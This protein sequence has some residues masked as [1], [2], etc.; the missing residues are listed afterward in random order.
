[1]EIV[2][3]QRKLGK[4]LKDIMDLCDLSCSEMSGMVGCSNYTLYRYANGKATMPKHMYIVI[5]LALEYYMAEHDILDG[6]EL[7]NELVDDKKVYAD[8]DWVEEA[9]KE[10]EKE[11]K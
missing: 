3:K 8:S 9:F 10:F 6:V 1:M 5:R 11:T 4:C 2:E 7:L